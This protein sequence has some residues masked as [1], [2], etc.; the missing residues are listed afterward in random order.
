MPQDHCDFSSLQSLLWA[1]KTQD[2]ID[3]T[4]AG[5]YER[6]RSDKLLGGES[7]VCCEALITSYNFYVSF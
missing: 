4:H 7:Q 2:L 5:H 3:T 1:Y 6:F